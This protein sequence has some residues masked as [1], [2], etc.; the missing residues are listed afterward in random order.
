MSG[1]DKIADRSLVIFGRDVSKIPCFRSTMLSG[2]LGGM[3]CGLGYFM[4]TSR[5]KASCDV[6]MACFTFITLGYW[7]QCRYTYSK[8]KFEMMR[9]QEALALANLYEG[10]EIERKIDAGEK[11][12]I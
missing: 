8:T 11:V 7:A 2:I 4:F 12:D 6:A 3:G 10:T 9:M 5:V 1:E